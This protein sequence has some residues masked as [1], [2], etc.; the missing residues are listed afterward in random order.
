MIDTDSSAVSI[1]P[2]TPDKTVGA[3]TLP[4]LIFNVVD[5]ANLLNT[6]T[7][8]SSMP[9]RLPWLSNIGTIIT[10]LKLALGATLE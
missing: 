3:D 5:A 4:T 7:N 8:I 9:I 10:I 6:P 2:A 1:S